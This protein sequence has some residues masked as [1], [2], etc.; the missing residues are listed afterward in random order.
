LNMIL[1]ISRR[2]L[3]ATG[4]AAVLLCAAG[5]R[6]AWADD[7]GA[8]SF[9]KE[10]AAQMAA[11]V[12]GPQDQAAK[13]Q[14]LAPLVDTNVDV[15][16]IG[17]FCMGRFWN[18]ASP[19]QRQKYLAVFH[20]VMLNNIDGHLG[21]YQGVS[22]AMGGSRPQGDNVVVAT[23]IT[24]PNN[25]PANVGW[26]VS[27]STGAPKVVDVVAEGASLRLQQR[28]DYASFLQQNGGSV[29][30][31]ISALERKVNGA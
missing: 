19:A 17:R 8:E 22:F 4:A 29:D 13:R 23:V 27:R 15:A 18:S 1:S 14:A 25:P 10:F 12:N 11:V 20:Q 26:V 9:V 21:E 2:Q 31:L 24:R 6:L 28:D 16:T 3:L 7:A 30:A 5:T